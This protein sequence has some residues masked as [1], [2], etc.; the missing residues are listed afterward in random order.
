LPI[1]PSDTT[2]SLALARTDAL[3]VENPF[4]GLNIGSSVDSYDVTLRQPIWRRPTADVPA[5]GHG[6]EWPQAEFALFVTGSLRDDDSS[7]LN[8]PLILQPDA[9]TGRE[10]DVALRFGQ[11]LTTRTEDDAMSL[12]SMF[13]FGLPILG[14][15]HGTS[16]Q[17]PDSDFVSWL[18]Q[19]QYVR[20]LGAMPA[21]LGGMPGKTRGN[22]G[23]AQLVLRASGQLAN[24]PLLDVEQF[25]IGGV[26]TVRGYP[27]NYFVGDEGVVASAELHL[28]IVPGRSGN[29]DRL[30][31]VPFFDTGYG[32][33][34]VPGGDTTS[35]KGVDLNSV[36]IG[37]VCNPTRLIN[38]QVYY[39]YAL[40]NRSTS[41]QDPEDQGLHFSLTA[42]AF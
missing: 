11:E 18:G 39:G 10:R 8:E 25:V 23:Q 3:V 24:R 9:L 36:G 29:P 13:S 42:Y 1:S 20:N 28:P 22:A 31:L 38:L 40:T 15:T 33:D 35:N 6:W 2:L 30:I 27:E 34:L 12:R 17:F 7:V 14:A 5:A 19:A 21:V 26:D 37:L 41:H 4:S 32:R 16:H